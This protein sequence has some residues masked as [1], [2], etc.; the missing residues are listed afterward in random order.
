M[1]E[2][3]PEVPPPPPRVTQGTRLP[4]RLA[5]SSPPKVPPPTPP[6]PPHND[7]SVEPPPGLS[8]PEKHSGTPGGAALAPELSDVEK[9]MA[10]KQPQLVQ[11]R[12]STPEKHSGTP[13]GAALAPELSDVE[14]W[15][16]GKQPQ[17]V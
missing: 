14:K 11:Q 12:L 13:G 15:M 10:G 3:R 17:L 16:A 2:S 8:T 5:L 1:S 7:T 6:R 9:W 4:D